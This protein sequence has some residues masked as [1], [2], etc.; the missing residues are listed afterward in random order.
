MKTFTHRHKLLTL[1]LTLGFFMW[2][3]EQVD[4][5]SGYY[6]GIHPVGGTVRVQMIGEG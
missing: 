4:R 5:F 6:W 1:C 3:G 2:L